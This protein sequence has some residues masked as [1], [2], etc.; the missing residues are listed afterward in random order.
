MYCG[1]T[2]IEESEIKDLFAAGK[3]LGV[4][5]LIQM[6]KLQG[7]M[8]KDTKSGEFEKFQLGDTGKFEKIFLNYIIKTMFA[9][10][11]YFI[12]QYMQL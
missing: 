7:S 6:G 12:I 10:Y 2:G 5:G 8:M 3:I 9:T 11:L 4:Y 1:Y